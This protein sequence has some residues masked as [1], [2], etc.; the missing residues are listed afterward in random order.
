MLRINQTT[1]PRHQSAPQSS[2]RSGAALVETAFVLPVFLIFLFAMWEFTHAYMV[3]NTINAAATKAARYGVAQDVT[4]Q[5]VSDMAATIINNAFNSTAATVMVKD[6][7]VFDE[8]SVDPDSISYGDLPDIELSQADPQQLFVVHI[9]VPYDNIAIMPPFWAK[10]LTLK[11][12][13]V[14]RHE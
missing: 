8:T 3:L 5:Q 1:R 9:E 14:M 7:S 12:Q 4:S 2:E 10:N 6:A 13:A 11:G